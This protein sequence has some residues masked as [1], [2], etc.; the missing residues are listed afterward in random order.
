MNRQDASN[1][2]RQELDKH[3]LTDWKVRISN[4]PNQPYLGLCSYKDKAILLNAYHCEIHPDTEIINTIRHE[5]AHALVGFSNGHNEIWAAKA[6][7]I[8]C[9]NTL[10]CSHLSLPPHVI[11]AIRSGANVEMVVEEETQVI[12]KV[13]HVVKKLEELCPYCGKVAKERFTKETVDKSGDIVKMISLE[14]FHIIFKKVPKATPFD[15]MVS[16]DWKDEIRNCQHDWPINRVEADN[17][18]I[19]LNQCKKCNEYRLHPFQIVGARMA[20]QG[21]AIGKGFGIFDDMG[22]GKTVQGLAVIKYHN[23]YTPTLYVV[24]SAITFN[25]FKQIIRWLGINYLPQIIRTGKDPLLPGLKSYIISYDLLRRL[26]KDKSEWLSK[27]IKCVILD[28][29]QQIKNP[30]ST[31]TTEV[32]KILKNVGTKVIPLSG[33]PW[34]NRGSEFFVALNAINPV[35]FH[36]YQSFINQ[37]VDTYWDGGKAKQGGIRNPKRFREFTSDILI[38]REFDEVMDVFPS[39]N[40]VP[41]YVKLDDLAQESYD[42]EVSNFVQWYNEQLAAKD[43]EGE[44]DSM[45]ILAKLNRMRHIVALAKIPAT[46]SF[47][48]EFLENTDKKLTIAVH[49]KDVGHILLDEMIK[50]VK[51]QFPVYK[52]TA[53]MTDSERFEAQEN[54]NKSPR[55]FLVCSTL[56]SGEG[57]DLQTCSDAVIHERQWNPANEDQFFPGRFKRIGQKAS[58]VTGTF[59]QGEGTVDEHLDGIVSGKRASFHEVMNTSELKGWSDADSARAIAEI[60]ISK[61]KAKKGNKET[62][63]S[64]LVKY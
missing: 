36:S 39:V 59:I 23:E 2:L 10:P 17:L 58:T 13:K 33:T 5:V 44:V 42:A 15:T 34:K 62:N 48:E 55:A 24:K 9:D 19:Q 1:L 64:Q 46:I 57:I 54:F 3:N 21:L 47:A 40:R 28:E 16:H 61:H 4:D 18:Q 43:Y 29:V 49:H 26:P 35:K 50:L 53:S 51:G 31:R 63:I 11:D 60:I 6:K 8:G 14:C 41:L 12:R 45:Q 37:W 7:E 25:W 27:N 22:L 38:R 32:R 20:E 52:I 56:A 30:D